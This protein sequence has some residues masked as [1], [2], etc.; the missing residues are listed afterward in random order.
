MARENQKR[1]EAEAV[2]IADDD[3][4]F[5]FLTETKMASDKVED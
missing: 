2:Q 3:D 4:W 5:P 1:R